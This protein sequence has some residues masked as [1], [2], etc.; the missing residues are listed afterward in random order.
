MPTF[1]TPQKNVVYTGPAPAPGPPKVKYAGAGRNGAPQL[2]AS[3][4]AEN[5]LVNPVA[6]TA[7]VKTS[8]PSAPTAPA[9]TMSPGKTVPTVAEVA[10]S[11]PRRQCR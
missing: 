8:T 3:P 7:P 6:E 2:P 4:V 10:L 1:M 5:A 11:V 9:E